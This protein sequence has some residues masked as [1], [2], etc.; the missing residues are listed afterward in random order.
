MVRE[1]WREGGVGEDDQERAREGCDWP[2]KK[3]GVAEEQ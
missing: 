3:N 1:T 2:E